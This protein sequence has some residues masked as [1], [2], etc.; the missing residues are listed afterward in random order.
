MVALIGG[1]PGRRWQ[2]P[3]TVQRFGPWAHSAG[4]E[5]R[6]APG[7][8]ILIVGPD[9]R[10]VASDRALYYQEAGV[11][12]WHRLG[13]EEIDELH[14]DPGRA[15]L[16]VTAGAGEDRRKLPGTERFASVACERTTSTRLVQVRVPLADG[17]TAQVAARRRPGSEKLHW[18]VRVPD[19]GAV[20]DDQVARAIHQVRVLHGL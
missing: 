6:L 11:T 4:P 3:T 1:R 2:Q 14:W 10:A 5:L 19:A 8:R 15:Q 16:A 18:V 7:E 13:W 12:G 17:R 20:D 9:G